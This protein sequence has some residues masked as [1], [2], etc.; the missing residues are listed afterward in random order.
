MN[1]G[2]ALRAVDSA[3]LLQHFIGIRMLSNIKQ[4]ETS[5]MATMLADFSSAQSVSPSVP[6]PASLM[7]GQQLDISI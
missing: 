6:I 3:S 2:A 7:V 1:A 5:Q 4:M